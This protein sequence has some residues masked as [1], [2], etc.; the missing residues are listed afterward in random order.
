MKKTLIKFGLFTVVVFAVSMLLVS[1]AC[2]PSF[3]SNGQRIL[4]TTSDGSG[5]R[6]E[7]TNGPAGMMQSQLAC[8]N[9]HGPKGHGGRVT[10]MMQTF[11][12]PNISWP[13]LTGQYDDH[14]PYT[15]ETVKQAIA[16]GV[17]PAGNSLEY[18]MPRWQM[19]AQ[20]LNDLVDYLKTLK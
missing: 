9:C 20:D 3:T 19:S 14:Q 15:D 5:E 16:Q 18:P 4:F 12:V 1:I 7:H 10:I 13:T 8:V 17:D 2:S 6:I 11:D